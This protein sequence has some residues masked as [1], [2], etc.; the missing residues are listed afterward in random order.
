MVVLGYEEIKELIKS[1]KLLENV[2]GNNI[3]P[4]GVDLRVKC[5]YRLKNGGYIGTK[6]G[7]NPEVENICNKL[8]NKFTLKPNEFVLVETMEK[9]NMPND[10]LAIILPR[11]SLFR[12]GVSLH[13]AVVD[14]GFI[15]TLTFG[16]KNLSEHP[17]EI[18]IGSKIGQIVFE[19]VKGNTKLYDGKYQGGKVT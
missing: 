15:G 9:V 5:I 8:G 4:A 14:P 6:K 19:V 12:C 16:M 3:Q 7:Q 18:E 10:L 17:F 13:T 1:K 2:D 11:S